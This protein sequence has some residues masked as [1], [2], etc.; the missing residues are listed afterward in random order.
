MGPPMS[1]TIDGKQYITVTGAPGSGN[2]FGGGGGGRGAAN[3]PHE[4]AK[5]FV[6]ALDGKE[7]LDP[8]AASAPAN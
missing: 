8:P 3:A 1:F 5:L 4:P 6:F 2:P 7:S